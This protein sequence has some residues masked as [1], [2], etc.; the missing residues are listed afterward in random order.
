MSIKYKTGKFPK[1]SP[2]QDSLFAVKFARWIL[3]NCNIKKGE[4]FNR[5]VYKRKVTQV[6]K[7]FTIF[8]R[9]KF[10]GRVV[11]DKGGVL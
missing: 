1:K 3:Q 10:A 6:A 8:Y 4:E 11:E 2:R 7:L 5:F 9:E